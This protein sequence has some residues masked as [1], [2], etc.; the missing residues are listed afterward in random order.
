MNIINF[1]DIDQHYVY[2]EFITEVYNL[3]SSFYNI[4]ILDKFKLRN[5]ISKI[6]PAIIFSTAVISGSVF[7]EIIKYL[8]L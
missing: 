2:L 7:M 1:D 6:K 8:N 5:L 3:R 4:Q